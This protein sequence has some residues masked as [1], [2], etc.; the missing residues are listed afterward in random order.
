MRH[1]GRC[2]VWYGEGTFSVASHIFEAF[3][4][5]IAVRFLEY[6]EETDIENLVSPLSSDP[7]DRLERLDLPKTLC[8]D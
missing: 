1:L 2:A 8:L 7:L 6:M 3:I 4:P 5:E